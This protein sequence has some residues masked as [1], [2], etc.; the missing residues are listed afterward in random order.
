MFPPEIQTIFDARAALEAANQND[1][2]FEVLVIKLMERMSMDRQ[3]VLQNIVQLAQG[4][5]HI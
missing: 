1:P 3:T 4:N 5:I 2:R